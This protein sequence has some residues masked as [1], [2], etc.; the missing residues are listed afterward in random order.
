MSTMT[1]DAAGQVTPARVLHSEWVKLRTLR[2]TG[3]TLVAAVVSVIGLGLIL[4]AVTANRWPHMSTADQA[5]LNP[6]QLSIGGY[7]LALFVIGVL[8]VLVISGE[9][10]T[11]MIRA[12]LAAVP[13]RLPVLWAKA[14]MFG[15]MTWVLMT[16]A[17]VVA[18]FSGQAILGDHG[19][20]IGDPGV[21]R[22]V[23]GV[24]LNLTVLAV[25]S[26]GIGTIVRST[27]GGLAS[28]FGLMLVLPSLA[29]LLPSSVADHVNQYLP[30]NAAMSLLETTP[31]AHQLQPWTGFAVFGLYAV[32]ALVAAA[33][34]LKRRD[35]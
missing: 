6:T 31:E 13:K 28:F 5:R 2:S 9:Y 16:A 22:V 26:V 14:A 24:G 7:Y 23:M 15:A 20:S 25:L 27:A 32:A 35:A 10:S 18:F 34:V 4:T 12:S 21:L 8:G 1:I 30:S 17:A 3:F 29:E 11:G 19:V 33:V